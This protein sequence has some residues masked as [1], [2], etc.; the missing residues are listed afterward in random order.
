MCQLSREFPRNVL[1]PIVTIKWFSSVR[2]ILFPS[3]SHN[4]IEKPCLNHANMGSILNSWLIGHYYQ[5]QLH[6]ACEELIQFEEKL[7]L[8]IKLFKSELIN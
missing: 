6:N 4:S 5:K 7:I 3:L 1:I 8:I 2:S